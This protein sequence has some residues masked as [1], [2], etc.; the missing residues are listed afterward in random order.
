MQSIKQ[1]LSKL[2]EMEM[3]LKNHVWF[4]EDVLLLRDGHHN[5]CHV[6]LLGHPHFLSRKGNLS[7]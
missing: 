3:I 2:N 4:I 1:K 7:R 5:I 6:A